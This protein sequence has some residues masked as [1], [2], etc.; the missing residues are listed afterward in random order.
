MATTSKGLATVGEFIEAQ[1][2]GF[3]ES[4]YCPGYLAGVYHRGEQIVIARGTR[5]ITTGD[6]MTEDTGFLMGSITKPFTA[7]LL[8]QCVE[9]GQID[10]DERVVTYLPEFELAPPAKFGEIRVRN[11]L[12][13]TTG[14]DGEF[15]WPN[16]VEGEEAL[17]YY[18]REL[19]RCSTL[20]DPGEYVSYSSAALLVVGRLLEV[21]TGETYHDL[22]RRELFGPLGMVDSCTSPE[23][24]ILRRTAV[25][26]FVDQATGGVRRTNMFMLPESWSAAG[27]TPIVTIADLLAFAR[28]HLADGVAPSGARVLSADLVQ[29]M[30]TVTIDMG[31][32]NVSPMGLGWPFLPFGETTVLTHGGAS[33]GGQAGL[34]LVP[35]HDF[36]FTGF[37]NSNGAERLTDQLAMWL[38]RDY[39]GLESP[40]VVSGEIEVADLTPYEGTYRSD[41][42]RIDVRAIDGQLEETMTYEPLD[43][44]QERIFSD[45]SGGGFPFPPFRVVPVGEALFAPAGAPLEMFNGLSRTRL[46]S[47]H[48]WTDGRP[49]Y[50]S[51]G[52]RMAR[53]SA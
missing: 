42:F 39:L 46:I 12:N 17:A 16:E 9:R 33:P 22:L 5:N 27:A 26:H 41:Q 34:L 7:T 35:E 13:G 49:H 53:R 37:G 52:G 45:F 4:G 24:A 14:I 11:L 36:A 23:E 40:D 28:T 51:F 47:F 38:L 31:T 29:Q 18:V 25:G 19:K 30:R 20:Y 15:F 48:G 6:P 32:P 43:E 21:V 44:T 2:A 50:H 8:F 3:C 1:A 10:L